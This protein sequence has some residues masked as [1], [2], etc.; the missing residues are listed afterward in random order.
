[1]AI[2]RELA[3]VSP[4]RYRPLLA[5]SL[6]NLGVY[7][8]ALGRPAEALPPAEQAVEAYRELAAASPDSYRP[9]LAGSLRVLAAALDDLGRPADADAAR[10]DADAPRDAQ[11]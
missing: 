5:R 6:S 2:R 3:A 4:D 11:A 7:C 1:M 9:A 8:S 10:R